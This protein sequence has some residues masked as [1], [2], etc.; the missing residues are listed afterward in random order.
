MIAD[1]IIQWEKHVNELQEHLDI[2]P[3]LMK[4]GFKHKQ[5]QEEG[6]ENRKEWI[7]IRAAL[8]NKRDTSKSGR[9]VQIS[10][11]ELLSGVRYKK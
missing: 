2:L 6:K 5:E 7:L 4:Q 8:I 3:T 1:E 11:S 10:V 9:G